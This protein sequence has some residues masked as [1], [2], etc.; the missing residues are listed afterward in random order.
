MYKKF[1]DNIEYINNPWTTLHI[2]FKFRI[3]IEQILI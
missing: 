3:Q 2:R 1:R